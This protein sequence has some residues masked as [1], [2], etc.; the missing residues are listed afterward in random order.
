MLIGIT[1]SGVIQVGCAGMSHFVQRRAVMMNADQELMSVTVDVVIPD[2]W[3]IV[4]AGRSQAGFVNRVH[5]KNHLH[6]LVVP[7]VDRLFAGKGMVVGVLVQM[8]G[9][10]VGGRGHRHRG[11]EW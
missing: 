2:R 6:H 9:Q 11:V 1:N 4:R 5:R 3:I 10:V 7:V 8:M